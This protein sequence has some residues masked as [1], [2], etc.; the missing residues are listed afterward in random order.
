MVTT[1]SEEFGLTAR[2]PGALAAKLPPSLLIA[3]TVSSAGE[4]GPI[5]TRSACWASGAHIRN[6]Q[7]PSASRIAPRPGVDACGAGKI[8]SLNLTPRL[9][10]FLH[11]LLSCVQKCRCF[12][13]YEVLCDV[14]PETGE[15][16]SASGFLDPMPRHGIHSC[17]RWPESVRGLGSRPA[18]KVEPFV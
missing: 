18:Q 6:T 4:F 13:L 16:T 17:P 2:T 15:K 5:R 10:H 9:H 11:R 8:V 3:S 7:P 12:R 14:I 1:V